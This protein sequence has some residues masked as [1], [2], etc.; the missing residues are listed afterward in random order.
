M[1]SLLLWRALRTL[2]RWRA[3]CG[4]PAG[5]LAAKYRAVEA[6]VE[7]VFSH[8]ESPM[9]L[10]ATADCRQI[11]VWGSC[12]AVSIG[13]PL[14]PQRR[15]G[16]ARWLLDNESGLV[17]AGQIR[18][19][20]PGE[21]WQRRLLPAETRPGEYQNGAYWATASGWFMDAVRE[22]SAPAARRILEDAYRYFE[23]QGIYECV[24]GEYRKLPN[25]VVSAANLYG[26]A[27]SING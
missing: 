23:R 12:Y 25:Y 11:D 27:K 17:Q 4:L 26:A 8:E 19:T 15:E 10:A 6:H 21:Y 1:E 20:A 9:L 7:R 16:I 3:A 18:H 13:F 14:S 24:N 22:V 2:E 5:D